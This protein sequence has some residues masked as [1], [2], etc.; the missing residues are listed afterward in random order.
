M[1][2]VIRCID[3]CNG[4]EN[5]IATTFHLATDLAISVIK[6]CHVHQTW[7]LGEKKRRRIYHSQQA[8]SWFWSKVLKLP[9]KN[10]FLRWHM[11]RKFL[12][13]RND[14]ISK[15][16]SFSSHSISMHI[17]AQFALSCLFMTFH[18]LFSFVFL[19]SESGKKNLLFVCDQTCSNEKFTFF[20]CFHSLFWIVRL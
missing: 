11:Q 3:I 5:E 14:G 13:D 15:L 7:F 8:S 18:S 17:C 6:A 20:F 16:L 2:D 9:K 12:I 10:P 19:L 4:T 1:L